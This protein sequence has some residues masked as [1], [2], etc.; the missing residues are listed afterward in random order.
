MTA[1]PKS[2][3]TSAKNVLFVCT[4]NTC[5]SP[6]AEGLFRKAL[7]SRQGWIVRSAGVAASVGSKESRDTA[8]VLSDRAASLQ[9]FRS[10]QICE[11]LIEEADA[12]FAMTLGHLSALEYDF[13]DHTDKFY[14]LGDFVDDPAL[15]G[16][17]P[18][19]IGQGSRAYQE[20]AKVLEA[21]FP[22]VLRFLEAGGAEEI[23]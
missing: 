12:V 20:V 4:G 14:L 16:D 5:R 9:G 6:M 18:D 7:G 13:P 2:P 17:V 8:K 10:Q 19:P 23:K 15:A 11:Q 1:M 3:L 22:G 21:A